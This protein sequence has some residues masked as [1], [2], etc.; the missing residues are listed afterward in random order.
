VVQCQPCGDA[1]YGKRISPKAAKGRPRA[2]AY[3]RCLGTDASRFG[4]ERVC[5]TTQVR[6]AVLDLA[7]WREVCELLAHPERLAEAYPRRRQ[8]HDEA[9]RQEYTT[10][11][12]QL[13]KLERGLARLL[14]SYAE[15]LLEKQE[16]EPRI[17]HLRQRIGHLEAQRRQLADDAALQ[18]ELQLIIGRLEDFASK[19]HSG[20][21]E[22]AWASQRKLIRTLVKRVEVAHDQVQV[23]FRVDPRPGDSSPEKKRLQDCRRSTLTPLV[24]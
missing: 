2:Y 23:V 21:A 5:Q 7:V 11:E 10:R 13:G 17:T 4:G 20:L 18:S 24:N 19:V 12:V 9:R 14:D 8:P 16:F 15:G 22:A 6:T 1:F 3:Y